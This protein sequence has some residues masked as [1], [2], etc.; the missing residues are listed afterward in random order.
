MRVY[1]S[2]A[3]YWAVAKR[4]QFLS[5]VFDTPP[6][7]KLDMTSH[8]T[9]TPWNDRSSAKTEERVIGWRELASVFPRVRMLRF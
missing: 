3:V 8:G 7:Q 9:D 1:S 6:G 5:K 4:H 2:G